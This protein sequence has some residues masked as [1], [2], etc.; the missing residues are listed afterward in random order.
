VLADEILLG[1]NPMRSLCLLTLLTFLGC[2]KAKPAIEPEIVQD[3]EQP[4]LDQS[5]L[6]LR[7]D[8]LPTPLEIPGDPLKR[9]ITFIEVAG[10]L[11]SSDKEAKGSIFLDNNPVTLYRFGDAQRAIAKNPMPIPVTLK[12]SS[13]NGR[14]VTCEV[15]FADGSMPGC[16]HL[17]IAND[18][19]DSHR[20][21]IN[22]GVGRTEVLRIVDLYGSPARPDALGDCPLGANVHFTTLYFPEGQPRRISVRGVRDGAGELE[23]D[24]NHL[25]LGLN[26]YVHSSTCLGYS[27]IKVH[28]KPDET[29]D[30]LKR[31]RRIYD[32]VPEKGEQARSFS[33][34][35]SPNE[36]GPHRLLVREGEELV[37]I[38]NLVDPERQQHLILEPELATT[39]AAEKQAIA[40]I[41]K[42]VGYSFSFRIE[43][44]NA[45]TYLYFPKAGEL[46]RLDPALRGL[47]NLWSL[48]FHEGHLPREGL[49]CL[50]HMP[51]LKGLDFRMSR[52]DDRG[53][54]YVK[55][56]SQLTI[57]SFFGSRGITDRGLSNLRGLKNLRY[58]DLRNESFTPDEPKEPRITDVGLKNLV[59]L[60]KLEYLNLQ[61]QLITDN[62]LEHLSGLTE[63]HTLSLSFSGITDAGLKHLEGLQKLHRLHINSNR[64]SP[65]GRAALKAKLPLLDQ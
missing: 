32:I 15:V 60:T 37:E 22:K 50:R 46:G 43:T 59:G 12:P 63:L 54:A 34:V 40:Q 56:M 48:S 61:G 42:I 26:G 27:P 7:S 45:V 24:P 17:T 5:A 62:G 58:L 44:K 11:P 1:V 4:E 6:F 29:A 8:P 35:L 52:I 25:G 47:K 57:M 28:L 38:H 65:Q 21:V 9:R 18:A 41:R 31:G 16:L 23:L 55:D 36:A 14:S 53:L 2:S 49:T 64:V 51:Q 20:L 10:D 39:S 19:S 13:N 30:P 3:S 33:L